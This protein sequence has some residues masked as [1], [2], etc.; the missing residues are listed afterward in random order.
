MRVSA[1]LTWVG[2]RRNE[3]VGR[4]INDSIWW[5][6]QELADYLNGKTHQRK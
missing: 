5:N 1:D 3:N 6:K 2:I 4:N